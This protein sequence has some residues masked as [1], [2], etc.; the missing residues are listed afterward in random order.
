MATKIPSPVGPHRDRKW[1]GKS[2][3]RVEDPKFLRGSAQYVDDMVFPGMLHV[4]TLRSPFAHARIVS[5]DGA[6]ARQVPGVHAVVTGPEAAEILDPLPDGGPSP[7]KHVWRVLAADK[8]RYSGEG[9]AIVVAENRYIAEDALNLIDVEYEP[10]EPIVDPHKAMADDSNLVH[11][12][13][14][15]NVVYSRKFVFGEVEKDFE[16]ADRIIKDRLH[17]RRMAA[18]PLDGAGSVALFDGGTGEMTIHTSSISITSL[19]F[20]LAATFKIPSNK[21]NLVPVIS[22]GSFGARFSNWRA[23]ATAGLASMVTGRPAKY[24]EDRLD[25]ILNGDHHASDRYYDVELAVTADGEFKSLRTRVVDDYG[26]GVY[27]GTGSHGN[28]MSTL[29]GPFRIKSAEYDMFAVLTNKTQQGGY[30]GFG[31]ECQNW[32]VDRIV[33]KAAREL[34]MDPIEIRRKNFIQ[35]DE[36]PYHIPTGNMYD[37]G[38]FDK[39]MDHA[40]ELFDYEEWR[41]KQ[42]EMRAEG[43]HVGIGVVSCMERS[44]YAATEFWFWFDDPPSEMTS[45]P[46]GITL[47]VDAIGAIT[48]TLY[49]TP[50]WGN[51]S[52]TMAAMLVAE[53][54]DVD[55]ATVAVRHHGTKGGLPAAGPGGSRLTVMYA[56][57]VAG[58]AAKIK[59]KSRRIAAHQLEVDPDDLDWVDGGFQ[60]RGAPSARK[61]FAELATAAHLFAADLP[62]GLQSGL[63]ASH[64]YDHPYTTKPKA[65]RSDLGVFYPC[66]GNA[67][68]IAMVEVDVETGNVTFLRY[69]AV[70]D[71]GTMVNPRSLEGQILGGTAQGIGT[72]LL[73]ELVYDEEGQLQSASFMDY[74]MPTAMEVPE[75][76]IGHEETP[77]PLTEHGI[78]GGGEAGRMM[79]P[80][81]ISSAIDDALLDFGVRVTELPATPE[82]LVDWMGR[83]GS[84]T[85]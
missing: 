12:A 82:R 74:L 34:E 3:K 83:D 72:A 80:A 46:E 70:H 52:D 8:V 37:S 21:L 2:I 45:T 9:V 26:I 24:V 40:I 25:H 17:W 78:K 65:D 7:D 4:A 38:S 60:V 47:T 73:E 68:H 18:I 14:G 79:A 58:A 59:D 85:E 75:L 27:I 81:A 31:S 51:S 64:V 43:R 39:V 54:F 13:L 11:E 20:G 1:V 62:E 30:R 55:P 77:S 15:T 67:C 61:E 22:G 33:D 29:V 56:G 44:V 66:T 36:F 32:V 16:E 71:A 19:S 57:A 53:E 76:L 69:A 50:F 35:P 5:I 28:A 23:V 63:E 10:L 6:A 41:G 42:A 48:A 49:S 84:G